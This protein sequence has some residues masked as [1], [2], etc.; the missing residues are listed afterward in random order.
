MNDAKEIKTTIK[1]WKINNSWIDP[2]EVPNIVIQGTM[3]IINELERLQKKVAL[4]DR[5]NELMTLWT[6][7][8]VESEDIDEEMTS[9]RK[10]LRNDKK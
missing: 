10:Q 2:Y 8:K 6:H 7:G 9:I 1:W 4:Y 5:Q 3:V